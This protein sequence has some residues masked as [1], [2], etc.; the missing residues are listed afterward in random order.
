MPLNEPLIRL[1]PSRVIVSVAFILIS[2]ASASETLTSVE[3]SPPIIR[4]PP[5]RL[6][7]RAFRLIEPPCSLAT[8]INAPL[9]KSISALVIFSGK[10][11]L[12]SSF[13]LTIPDSDKPP[14]SILPPGAIATP[15]S[16]LISPPTKVKFCPGLTVKFAKTP[17]SL[18]PVTLMS[19]GLSRKPKPIGALTVNKGGLSKSAALN[20]P[21]SNRILLALLP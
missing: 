12:K 11:K 14:N 13:K 8:L 16:K 2:P 5:V 10:L 9:V 3:T 7:L 19:A 20:S 21:F 6:R 18:L 17:V 1:T 4:L 15:V